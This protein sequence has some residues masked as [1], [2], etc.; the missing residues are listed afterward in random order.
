MKYY[1][2][3]LRKLFDSEDALKEAESKK[4]KKKQSANMEDVP[5]EDT[6]T[7]TPSRKALATEVEAADEKVREAYSNY[8]LAKCK[9]EE[10]SKKYLEE[11]NAILEPAEQA[12]KD[13]ETARYSAISR[14][15][16][17][18]GAYQVTY[19]GSRAAEE[20]LKALNGMNSRANNL[21]K[22]LF[23]F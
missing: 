5:V 20:M 2:E 7:E 19:T 11:V 10:L 12:V 21:F 8:E 15:N 6:A 3:K 17:A 14:F 23:W 9:V 1:S 16:D 13:A 4:I 18:Y 22:E